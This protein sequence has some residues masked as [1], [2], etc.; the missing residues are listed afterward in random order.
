MA[1]VTLPDSHETR[2]AAAAIVLAVRRYLVP[3][4]GSFATPRPQASI[5]GFLGTAFAVLLAF[6]VFL[7]FVSYVRAQEGPLAKQSP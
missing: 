7:S 3:P 5:F 4:D 6:V 1:G 2:Q